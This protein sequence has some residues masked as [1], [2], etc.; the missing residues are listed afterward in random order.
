[1]TRT[2][3]LLLACFALAAFAGGCGGDDEP[4]TPPAPAQTDTATTETE[5][6]APSAG[7]EEV[8]I[9]DFAYDPADAQVKVGQKIKWTNED[10]APHDVDSQ[11]G[12]RIKSEVMQKGGTFEFTAKEAG[13]VSYI[14]SIHPNMK[15]KLTITE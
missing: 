13:E 10:T 9:K 11:S 12:P 8:K 4:S 5:T 3:T 15:A 7:G 14:C 2:L 6:T 1:M